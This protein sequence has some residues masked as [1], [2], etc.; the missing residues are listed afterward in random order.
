MRVVGIDTST[1]TGGIALLNDGQVVAEYS[2]YVTRR[3]SE[4]LMGVLDNMLREL[5]WSVQGLQGVAVA[6]GPGSFT[7]TRIGVTMAKVLGYSLGIPIGQVVTLDAIAANVIFTRSLVCPVIC[8]RRDLVYN[9]AYRINGPDLEKVTDY[10]V[11]KIG[12]V[13]DAIKGRDDLDNKEYDKVIFLGDGALRHRQVIE[14]KLGNLAVIG[15]PWYLGPR[16]GVVA[17]MGQRQIAAGNA[18][19]AHDLVPFY[20]GKSSAEKAQTECRPKERA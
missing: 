17:V 6:I 13:I 1:F 4:S 14:G 5:D 15:P 9:A 18:V 2:A 11:G 19:D 8:A 16:P 20:M 10:N 7:G 12:E 3:N